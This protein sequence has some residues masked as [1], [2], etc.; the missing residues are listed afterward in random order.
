MNTLNITSPI[1]CQ[2]HA[3]VTFTATALDLLQGIQSAE[4]SLP[5][6]VDG[7]NPCEWLSSSVPPFL[8]NQ[9]N[10]LASCTRSS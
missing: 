4:E 8:L 3:E 9:T 2:D 1:N 10:H 7:I 6:P 5:N